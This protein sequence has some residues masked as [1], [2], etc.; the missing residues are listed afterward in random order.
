VNPFKFGSVV[1]GE[2]FADREEETAAVLR[3]L[4][5]GNHLV[6][7]SPRRFG[8]T[9]LVMR[10]T[11]GLGRPVI[12]L[13]LQSVTDVA[14]FA[15]SLLRK[16]IAV[17]RWEQV[18]RLL[19]GFRIVPTV[20]LN[21]VTGGMDVSF[22][23][24]VA[25]SFAELEDVLNLIEQISRPRRRPI[26]I[27]DEFSQATALGKTLPAQL[28]AVLQH[29][30]AVNYVFL[31]SMESMMRDIFESKRSPFYHFGYVMRLGRLP[32]DEFL[33]FLVDRLGQVT[34]HAAP[35]GQQILE[36]TQCHPYNTQL[37]AFYCYAHLE[38]QAWSAGLIDAVVEEI[39]EV[40]GPAYDQTWGGLR[41]TDRKIL[42]TLAVGRAASTVAKPT[43]TVYTGI[44]RLV[45]QGYLVKNGGFGFEDPFFQHWVA[46]MKRA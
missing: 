32:R 31:G 13:D 28:R 4:D 40:H 26:V 17:S 19:S 10:A 2:Y 37:L 27:L 12:H 39:L 8:K 7:I 36:F 41:P 20:E 14:D 45:R 16:V 35:A 44:Q 33:A 22:R 43:S 25:D 3:V 23:P 18:K 11:R 42:A 5:S 38:R 1:D 21:P 34:E 6:M 9:S 46:H 24:D 29:H 30:S 15:A